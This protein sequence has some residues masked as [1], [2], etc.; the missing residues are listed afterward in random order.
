MVRNI[1]EQ[2]FAR[3]VNRVSVDK[4]IEHEQERPDIMC[5]LGYRYV[6]GA[7]VPSGAENA[8]EAWEDPYQPMVIAGSR[9]PHVPLVDVSKGDAALSTLDLVKQ[10]FLLIT[11]DE[12]SGWMDAAQSQSIPMDVHVITEQSSPIRDHSSRIKELY[13]M[14]NGEAVLVRPDGHIA[15][16]GLAEVSDPKMTLETV[17]KQVLWK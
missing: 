4:T 17:L 6:K 15:W 10:N 2:A 13:R 12:S 8:L 9:M 14:E 16:R 1:M 7:L 5:E 11:T 3:Y